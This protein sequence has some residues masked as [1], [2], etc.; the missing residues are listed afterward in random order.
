MQN[1]HH[2]LEI[3]RVSGSLGAEIHNVNLQSLSDATTAQIQQAFLEHKVIFFR[4][5]HLSP[6]QFLDFAAKFGQPVEYPFVKGID[7]FPEIIQV[8]KQEHET[9]NFGGVWHADT[10]YLAEPPKG[11]ILLAREVPAYG[12]DTLFADQAAAFAALSEGLK[13]TL[14]GLRG[15]SSSAKADASKT[16]EDRIKDSGT[17]SADLEACH[18]VVRTHPETGRKSLYVNVAHTVRFDGWTEAESQPLLRYLFEHQVRPEF[19]CR[20]RWEPGSIALWD[21]RTV[22]HNPVNDYHGFRRSMH[23]ITLAGDKPV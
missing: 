15:V 16:R 10:T 19:T 7:G 11:T 18:P 5:Q 20:F 14:S 9:I 3:H 22:L 17:K 6:Q 13:T 1:D 21:N 8:L 2:D 4:N 23:R 12:G